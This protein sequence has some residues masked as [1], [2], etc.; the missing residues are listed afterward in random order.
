M[1]AICNE[2]I[3]LLP[4]DNIGVRQMPMEITWTS[5]DKIWNLFVDNKPAYLQIFSQILANWAI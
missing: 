3:N 5:L 1:T 2:H 4:S